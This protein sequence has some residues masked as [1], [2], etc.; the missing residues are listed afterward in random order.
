[1]ASRALGIASRSTCRRRST[2][3]TVVGAVLFLAGLAGLIVAVLV[4]PHSITSPNALLYSDWAALSVGTAILFWL[5]GSALESKLHRR[6]P[7]PKP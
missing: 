6:S 4:F 2:L 5:G 7:R 1:V 3:V